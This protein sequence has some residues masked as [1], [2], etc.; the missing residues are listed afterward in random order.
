MKSLKGISLAALL[1]LCL[2]EP[3]PAKE[4]RGITPLRSTRSDVERLLGDAADE[5][6]VKYDLP[7]VKVVVGYEMFKCDHA[8]PEGWPIPPPG[9]NVPP[10]TVTYVHIAPKW[11]RPALGDTGIDLQGFKRQEGDSQHINYIN[12]EEGFTVQTY[13]PA[14]GNIETVTAYI[15]EPTAKDEHMRCPHLKV[16]GTS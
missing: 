12:E 1:S 16:S 9:W 10:G 4:W 8:P 13:L 14:G 15:Y 6:L 7:D 5:G 2:C 11:R 3:C